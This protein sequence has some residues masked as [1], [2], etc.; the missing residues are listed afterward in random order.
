MQAARA[1]APNAWVGIVSNIDVKTPRSG[2]P[3]DIRAA[4]LEDYS[5]IVGTS[6]QSS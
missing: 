1:A 5:G 3:A 2:H 6:T 4:E